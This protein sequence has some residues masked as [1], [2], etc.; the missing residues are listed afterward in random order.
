VVKGILSYFFE[1][2]PKSLSV[3]RE[4]KEACRVVKDL[5]N[6]SHKSGYLIEIINSDTMA[7]NI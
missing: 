1:P 7:I 6:L 5:R 3:N 4:E 2:H